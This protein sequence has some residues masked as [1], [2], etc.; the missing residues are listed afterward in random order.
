MAIRIRDE[1][2]ILFTNEDFTTAFSARGRPGLSPARLAMV[3]ILQFGE[4]LSDRQA[5]EA[6]RGRIDWKY[7]LG[8]EFTD[9]A[10]APEWLVS[11]VEPGWFDRYEARTED[12]RLPQNKA[13]RIQFGHAIGADGADPLS[14][15]TAGSRRTGSA[16]SR[17]SRR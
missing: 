10:A 8:L 17:R 5:A 12:Y 15:V 13:K 2:G 1:L 4:G 16:T 14:A 9:P 7:A 11:I 6:V 3:S